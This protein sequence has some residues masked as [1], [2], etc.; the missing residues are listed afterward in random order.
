MIVNLDRW[1]DYKSL[2]FWSEE[3]FRYFTF[4]NLEF[5]T[6][7]NGSKT[8]HIAVLGFHIMIEWYINNG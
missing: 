5:E 4:I 8:L 7:D 6:I 2:S 1:S 3:T